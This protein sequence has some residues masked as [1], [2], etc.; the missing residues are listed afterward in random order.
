MTH[1]LFP[2]NLDDLAAKIAAN[3]EAYPTG[4]HDCKDLI[5]KCSQLEIQ[6][7]G[8]LTISQAAVRLG[9]STQTLRNWEEAGTLVPEG[10]TKKGHRRYKESQ[11]TALVKQ[12]MKAGE[13][14]LPN[15]T[16]RKLL[17]HFP[18]FGLDDKINISISQ[19]I[20]SGK[21]L[22]IIDSQDGLVTTRKFFK[23][24]ED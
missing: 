23:I 20:V 24:K 5:E 16:I 17:E 19:D 14:F 7:S 18:N 9:V 2:K 12:Q 13:I 6:E 4:E 3:P 10:K 15:I 21:V 22:V 11:I 1:K 8:N